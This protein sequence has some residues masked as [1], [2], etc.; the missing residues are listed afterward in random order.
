[1]FEH[2]RDNKLKHTVNIKT[3]HWD[4]SSVIVWQKKV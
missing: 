2:Q 3:Q 4:R 1:M